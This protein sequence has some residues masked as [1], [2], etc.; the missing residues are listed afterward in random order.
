MSGHRPFSELTEHF[1]EEDRRLIK[2]GSER[3]DVKI[4]IAEA[5]GEGLLRENNE[6]SDLLCEAELDF[7]DR[8]LVRAIEGQVAKVA[9]TAQDFTPARRNRINELTDEVRGWISLAESGQAHTG[10]LT[11]DS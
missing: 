7:S 6:L 5:I 11:Q 10:E 1:T 8:E 4:Q 3:L 2:I 9:G